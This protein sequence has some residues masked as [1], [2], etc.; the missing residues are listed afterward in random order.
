MATPLAEAALVV[1]AAVLVDLVPWVALLE[2]EPAQQT[3]L[4][5]NQLG[6]HTLTN[7]IVEQLAEYIEVHLLL[8]SNDRLVYIQV[9]GHT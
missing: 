4:D 2:V 8:L 3:M 7:P 1:M 9:Q 5:H 6:Q